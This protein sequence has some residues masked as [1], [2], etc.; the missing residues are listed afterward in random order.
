V[1]PGTPAYGVPQASGTDG[2]VTL[3][4]IA[5]P[6][7]VPTLGHLALAMMAGAMGLAAAWRRRRAG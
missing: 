2:S 3:T 6:A 4:A 7:A 1:G 5:A